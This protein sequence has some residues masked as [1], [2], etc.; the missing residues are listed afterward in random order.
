MKSSDKEPKILFH[1]NHVLVAIKPAG[2]VVQEDEE[3]ESISFE[4]WIKEYLQKTLK[5]ET[6]FIKPVHRLDKPVE[7]LVLFARSSKALSRLHLTQRDKSFEKFYIAKIS[8]HLKKP[9][10]LLKHSLLHGDFRAEVVK[11]GGKEAK[12]R[13]RKVQESEQDSLVSIKLLTGRYHQIRAQFAEIGH[14]IVGDD[15]YQS[16]RKYKKNQ[17]AL[18][19]TKLLFPHPITK[20]RLVF[21]FR[22]EI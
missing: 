5:K 14:P 9:R 3:E 2:M 11:E 18:Y 4:G 21:K 15:R 8:G 1:D 6:I 7:G 22:P 12:L 19:H 17:I 10:G 16:L 13:Y 20:K